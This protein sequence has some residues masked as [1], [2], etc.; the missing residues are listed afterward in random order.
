MGVRQEGVS[1]ATHLEPP[2]TASRPREARQGQA[3]RLVARPLAR[4]AAELQQPTAS[5]RTRPARRAWPLPATVAL[6][7]AA[8]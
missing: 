5:A 1:E 3:L 6:Y 4:A 7:H 2:A 8:P